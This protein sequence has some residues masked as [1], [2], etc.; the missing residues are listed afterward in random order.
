MQLS[1]FLPANIDLVNNMY[2]KNNDKPKLLKIGFAKRV[3]ED[4]FFL[5]GAWQFDTF[6]KK[7]VSQSG[8]VK[9]SLKTFFGWDISIL[10]DIYNKTIPN[11]T[12]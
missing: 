12:F 7:V 5:S 9:S 11:E 6:S 1:N 4:S 8:E 2:N 10:V 3:D